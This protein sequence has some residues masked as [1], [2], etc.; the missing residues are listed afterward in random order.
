MIDKEALQDINKKFTQLWNENKAE[1]IDE[2]FSSDVKYHYNTESITGRDIIRSHVNDWHSTFKR[3]H[4]SA[5]DVIFVEDKIIQRWTGKGIFDG[6]FG[7]LKP[8]QK[9]FEYGGITILSVKNS[10]IVEVWIYT[11]LLAALEKSKQ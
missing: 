1:I 5:E 10:K 11:D 2:I 7:G 3:M 4:Y 8:T 9:E 6:A